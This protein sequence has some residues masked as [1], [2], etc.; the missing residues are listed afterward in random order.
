LLLFLEKEDTFMQN[1]LAANPQ[2]RLRRDL[3][4]IASIL[5]KKCTGTSLKLI[6]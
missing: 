6:K 5:E 1:G 3:G 2:G 4:L